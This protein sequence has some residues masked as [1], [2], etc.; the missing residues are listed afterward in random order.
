MQKFKQ[1]KDEMTSKRH[2][3]KHERL[4]CNILSKCIILVFGHFWVK[5]G[6]RQKNGNFGI[7][8]TKVSDLN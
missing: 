8:L 6:K 7:T 1:V 3:V 2:K 4:F 5:K